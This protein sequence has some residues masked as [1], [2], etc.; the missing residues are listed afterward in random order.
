MTANTTGF[1]EVE[2]AIV[3]A[4]I[5]MTLVEKSFDTDEVPSLVTQGQRDEHHG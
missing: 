3:G 1:D 4:W 5:N 2:V